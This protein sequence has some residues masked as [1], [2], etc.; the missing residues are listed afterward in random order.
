MV[1]ALKLGRNQYILVTG[2]NF[3]GTKLHR[4]GLCPKTLQGEGG[5][6][7]SHIQFDRVAISRLQFEIFSAF[8]TVIII[9]SYAGSINLRYT[10]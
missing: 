9:L 6:T 1:E 2:L 3:Q 5:E 8:S 7:A 10:L 4:V